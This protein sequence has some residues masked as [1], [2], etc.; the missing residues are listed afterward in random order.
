M[1]GST[2]A[3]YGVRMLEALRHEN[4]ETHLIISKWAQRTI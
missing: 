3:I 2:G 4:V 1:T